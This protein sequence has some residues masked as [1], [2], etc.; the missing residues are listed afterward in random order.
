M[1]RTA[2]FSWEL[3]PEN[4]DPAWPLFD[5]L[6]AT[7]DVTLADQARRL[8]TVAP[9]PAGFVG[10]SMSTAG[11]G[12]VN[13][14]VFISLSANP[15]GACTALLTVQSGTQYLVDVVFQNGDQFGVDVTGRARL[16]AQ[17]GSLNLTGNSL[18]RVAMDAPND[19]HTFSQVVSLAPGLYNLE[20]QGMGLQAQ[21]QVQIVCLP[22]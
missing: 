1:A 7:V 14:G 17:P 18:W 21:G 15:R 12:D 16:L 19:R 9:Q 10:F 11:L 20:V 5:R 3:V 4:A 6:V 2:V 8:G 22:F 13:S